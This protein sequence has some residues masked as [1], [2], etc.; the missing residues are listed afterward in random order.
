MALHEPTPQPAPVIQEYGLPDTF[1]G[2]EPEIWH[3]KKDD[4][5]SAIHALSNGIDW[6][7]NFLADHE[8]RFGRTNK[9]DKVLA[10]QLES[11]LAQMKATYDKLRSLPS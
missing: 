11:D 10:E 1:K 7:S 5:Y 3:V 6:A 9:R 2:Y 4:I 8:A